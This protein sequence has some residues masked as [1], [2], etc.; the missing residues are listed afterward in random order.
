MGKNGIRWRTQKDRATNR[1]YRELA[2]GKPAVKNSNS[3]R[4]LLTLTF[5]HPANYSGRGDPQKG[6]GGGAKDLP[7]TKILGRGEKLVREV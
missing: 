3:T 1:G 2:R 5:E 4:T 6:K 7:K